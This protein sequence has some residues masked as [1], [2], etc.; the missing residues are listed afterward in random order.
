MTCGE[1]FIV[2]G[3]PGAGGGGGAP[4]A[5]ALLASL[6]SALPLTQAPRTTEKKAEWVTPPC[7]GRPGSSY[8][9]LR[10]RPDIQPRRPP[11]ALQVP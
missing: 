5:L 11:Q 10:W 2:E 9:K 4:S 8:W 3:A 7:Q 1:L 6:Q